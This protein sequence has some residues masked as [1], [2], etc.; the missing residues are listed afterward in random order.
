MIFD[1]SLPMV[2]PKQQDGKHFER[3]M[4]VVMRTADRSP[5]QSYIQPM[6]EK[7]KRTVMSFTQS[8]FYSSG[9]GQEQSVML[10]NTSALGQKRTCAPQD[11]MSALPPE[12]DMCS[13]RG[14][15]C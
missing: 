6:L 2:A 14:H 11:V 9:I 5:V 12:A 15:V 8:C 13:A 4:S 1:A 7:H 3:R 10:E